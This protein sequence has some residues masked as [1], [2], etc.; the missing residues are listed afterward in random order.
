M[1]IRSEPPTLAR[2]LLLSALPRDT[3]DDID[4]D[5]RELYV[6]R[7]ANGNVTSARA[8]YWRETLSFSARFLVERLRT[9][10]LKRRRVRDDVSPARSASHSRR[11]AMPS[12]IDARLALRMLVKYPG[13]SFVSIAGLSIAIA[14]G[15]IVFSVVAAVV[16]TR[17][18]LPDGHRLVA[19]SNAV[20]AEPGQNQSTLRDYT[21]WRSAL[22]S[23]RDVSAF[24]IVGRTLV[25]P[26]ASPELV[27]VVRMSASGFQLARSAPL[28]G[29]TVHDDDERGDARVVVIGY[30]EWQ[31]RFA[32]N[33]DVIGKRVRLGSE[34]YTIIGVMPNG[35]RFPVN[36]GYWIPLSFGPQERARD[37]VIP[38]TI[39]GRLAG[40]ATTE[41]ASAQLAAIGI[42]MAAAYPDTHTGLR[43]LVRPYTRAFFDIDNAGSIYEAHLF[44]LF[45]GLVLVV[46]ATNVSILV[47]AR[48]A[49]RAGEIAVRTALGASRAR[50]VMQLFA[51]SLAMCATA[52]IV[53][54]VLAGVVLTQVQRAAQHE[55]G[56]LPFWI[57]LRLSPVVIGY[58][59]LLALV[60]A[61][62]TGIVP[63]L[64]AT[65]RRVQANLQQLS[66][67]GTRMQLGRAW[68]TL[69]VAQV[70]VAVTVLPFALHFAEE[71]VASST[72]NVGYPAD[73]FLEASVAM[74][75]AGAERCGW[76]GFCD[77]S[78]DTSAA[79]QSAL[80][81]RFRDRAAEF[82]RRTESD[83]AVAGVAVHARN[84]ERVE[85]ERVASSLPDSL[86]ISS[87]IGRIGY[88]G[89]SFFA[90]YDLP[91]VAGRG[92]TSSDAHTGAT[93][94][95]VN[96]V[97]ARN[98][99]GS[100]PA[101]GR[102]LRFVHRQ[103]GVA[104][105]D[106]GPW[107]EI[108]G[109]VRD[110]DSDAYEPQ[111]RIYRPAVAAELLPPLDIVVRTHTSSA[112]AFAPHLRELAAAVDPA[113]QLD[114]LT[115][116]AE[117]HRQSRQLSR[118]VGFGVIA[119]MVSALLLSAAGI[120]AM[121]SFTVTKR[122]R[123]IGIR[124]AL[125]ADPARV[126]RSVFARASAQIVAGI[127]V[128]ILGTVALDRVAGRGPVHDGNVLAL[129]FVGAMMATVGMLAAVGPARRGLAI[130][131][132][133][134]LREE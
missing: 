62:I 23:V 69:I 2:R 114:G 91:L 129:V 74:E 134:A 50:V 47:Y 25:I 9:R 77:R 52:A 3:R 10:G 42:R 100:E 110:F 49:T 85:I 83:P 113:L 20:L 105:L 84:S 45:I 1:T 54:L 125:G 132:T 94:V 27:R 81:A 58:A 24:T 18:P 121:M 65:G 87:D 128:G 7:C 78:T 6:R 56:T 123:E 116:A 44:Q 95:V 99:F 70:A 108:V 16:D 32:A 38:L 127:A 12:A 97:F 89:T 53:G 109:V 5:L 15:V 86:R 88:V 55:L 112:A 79:E 57:Q 93:A 41:S 46:V 48:T 60:G 131:P 29:R 61:A 19:M 118:W 22:T 90:M 59:L 21:S 75:S 115:V 98:Q 4:G 104:P 92:F 40:G 80:V 72:G 120:Y 33:P 82:V 39:A 76:I 71:V 68:T 96:Q 130:Q 30:D 13:L 37:G 26:N 36:D 67:N 117:R 31:R 124:S 101:L 35:F 63:A 133:E 119:A 17:L 11:G 43:P 14:I 107:L 106:A 51:E 73:A 103:R 111:G 34:Q 102:R 28:L 8:W 66:G 64:K 122:R 126:L